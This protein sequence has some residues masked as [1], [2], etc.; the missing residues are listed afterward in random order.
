[1]TD[2]EIEPYLNKPVRVTLADRRVIAGV[3]RSK[4]RE[5][6]HYTIVSEPVR[7]G[8]ELIEEQIAGGEQI[9]DIEDASSDPAARL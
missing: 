4:G 9:V 7:P 8:D 2:Q 1:M 6:R 3:L 5:H